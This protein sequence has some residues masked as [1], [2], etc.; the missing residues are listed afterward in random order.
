MTSYNDIPA[1]FRGDPIFERAFEVMRVDKASLE[2]RQCYARELRETY[3]LDV[4]KLAE[5]SGLTPD[6][7]ERL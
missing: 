1:V 5:L 4:A 7:V 2:E 3:V 6:E